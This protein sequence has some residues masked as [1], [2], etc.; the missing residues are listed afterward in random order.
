MEL[1]AKNASREVT[2]KLEKELG[3]L[4]NVEATHY[5]LEKG[6]CIQHLLDGYTA[7]TLRGYDVSNKAVE[8]LGKKFPELVVEE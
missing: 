7:K 1:S 6:L 5:I 8:E 2:E 3:S 4:K